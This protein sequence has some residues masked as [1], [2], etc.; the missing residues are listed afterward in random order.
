MAKKRISKHIDKPSDVKDILELT[1]DRACEKSLIM[2]WFADFGDGPRFEP[3][4][5]VDIPKGYYGSDKK[6]NKNQFTTTVGLWV[7]NKSFIEPFADIIG[8][9]NEAVTDKV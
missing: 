1:H 8:Y 6:K 9:I 2:E 3:Y 4:D 7:F 5:T